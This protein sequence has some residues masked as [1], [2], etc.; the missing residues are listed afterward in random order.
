[1]IWY[2]K[3]ISLETLQAYSTKTMAEFLDLQWVEI[4]GDFLKMSM[5]VDERTRQPYG[6]LHGG[7]SCVLAETIGS[8]ASALVINMEK[9]IC[10]GQE[11]N[12]SHLRPVTSGRVTATCTPWHLGKSTHVWN[13]QIHNEAG[14]LTCI[15]KLTVAVR[16]KPGG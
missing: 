12:A 3:N 14:E 8:V 11:I 15:S 13:I 6:F 10:V 5:P 7:A 2:D 9:Y 4:G 16:P 1:M